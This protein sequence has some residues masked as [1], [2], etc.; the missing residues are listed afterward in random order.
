MEKL[1]IIYCATPEFAIAP[2]QQLLRDKRFN[3]LC[4]I[5]QEDK[6]K[7]RGEKIAYPA[8]KTF[9]LSN[10]LIV[11]QPQKIKELEQKINELKPDFIM[12]FA[13]GQLISKEIL[14]IPRF[15]CINIHLSFLPKY[16]G[17]SPVQEA[18]LQNDTETGVTFMLMDETLDTGDIIL[19]RACKISPQDTAQM[20][21]KKLSDLS[22]EL[23]PDVLIRFA[24]GKIKPKPQNN[25]LATYSRKIKKNHGLIDFKKETAEE[26]L[27]KIRAFTPWPGCYFFAKGKRIK[28]IQAEA[29][30]RKISNEIGFQTKQGVLI[31]KRL[32]MEG[33]KEMGIEE[34]LRGNRGVFE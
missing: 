31:P 19:Q 9:A 29:G 5:T 6:P 27:R 22:A 17:A 10:K 28:L 3:V 20:L 32:Q 7:G 12:V 16:R 2:L 34:F 25:A 24:Q 21:L 13:Y 23:L 4:A 1:K 11:L 8:M 33:K 15:G 26:I 30:E 18:I 14:E